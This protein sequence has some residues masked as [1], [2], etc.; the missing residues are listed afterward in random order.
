MRLVDLRGIAAGIVLSAWTVSCFV[1]PAKAQDLRRHAVSLLGEPKTPAD[2]KAFSWVNPDAPKGGRVRQFALGSFDSLNQF[3]AQGQPAA[4]LTLIYDLLFA[5]NPDEAATGYGL[6]AE[7]LSYPADYSSATFGLRPSARFNDGK[8]ITP[9]DVVFSLDALKK[10]SPLYSTYYQHVLKAEKT[11]PNEVRFI[12]D[13]KDNRELPQIISELPILPKHWWESKSASGE[14]RDITKSS[15]EVPI[16]SGPYRVK[17]FEPG[18]TITYERVADWWAKD[19]PVS[20]GQWNFDTIEIVYFRDRIAPFEAFKRGDLD[21]WTESSAKQWAT[22]FEFP[23]IKAG[24]VKKETIPIKRVAAMQAFVMNLRRPLFQDI[25]VRKAL[26]LALD[27]EDANKNLF[28]GLYTRLNSYFDNSELAARG[29]PQG[30]ELEILNK[31][32][33]GLPPEV[34]TTEFKPPSGDARHNLAS[35]SKLL[36]EAG[37]VNKG[38]T[39][40]DAAGKRL[41]FEFLLDE[42]Q[43]ERIVQPFVRSLKLLGV[44]VT[45]RVV[46][47]AQYQRRKDDFDYDMILDQFAQ[48]ESPGNEQRDFFG[49]ASADV[50]GRHN[51]AGIKNKAIDAII[52]DVIF[53]KDRADLIAATRALDR[54]LLW[55]F[56]VIPTWTRNGEWVAYWNKFS[57]PQP[58]PSR[59]VS[60]LQTWWLD[61][62]KAKALEAARK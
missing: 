30:R 50:R 21:Y 8:P 10:A 20:K 56:Y 34:F 52:E 47:S 26:N 35:A 58:L 42:P 61:P 55:N 1:A 48:S 23:A 15:L 53:A 16:G 45:I 33:D 17:S 3:P 24:L 6:I 11:G 28:F 5:R 57:R 36:T 29:L 46:D 44:G 54:A 25:R 18:R 4:G 59:L 40:V 13:V 2:F 51:T 27:F 12:F 32:K 38:G 60:F 43:L 14:P 22:E 31:V 19:L 39:L 7:W 37:Y 49:S 62:D 41:A 9:E